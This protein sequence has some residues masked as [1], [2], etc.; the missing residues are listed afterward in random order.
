[1]YRF[2]FLNSFWFMLSGMNVLGMH[3][4]TCYWMNHYCIFASIS[5]RESSR[6]M[7]WY[8]LS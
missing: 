7:A 2:H 3:I 1:M 4:E 6:L 8:P 5:L